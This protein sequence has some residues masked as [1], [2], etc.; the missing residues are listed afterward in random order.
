MTLAATRRGRGS[1]TCGPSR[2]R[3]SAALSAH[4]FEPLLDGDPRELERLFVVPKVAAEVRA[5][6]ERVELERDLRRIHARNEMTFI[7][8]HPHRLFDRVHPIGHLVLDRVA[9]RTGSAIE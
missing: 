1:R 3:P 4:R 2:R 6:E 9:H 8:R 5:E 7:L